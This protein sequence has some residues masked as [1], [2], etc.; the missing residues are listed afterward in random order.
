LA[1]PFEDGDIGCQARVADLPVEVDDE[2]EFTDRLV[3]VS[4]GPLDHRH[5]VP[6]DRFAGAVADLPQGGEGLLS[7]T[8][9]GGTGGP[10][11]HGS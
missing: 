3:E 2:F 10:A 6:G 9:P 11:G 5:V 4:L 1:Q 7:S 8:A